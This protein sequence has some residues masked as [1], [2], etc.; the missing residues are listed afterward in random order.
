VRPSKFFVFGM[1]F[2]AALAVAAWPLYESVLRKGMPW[3]PNAITATY[4]STQLRQTG[5]GDATV[6]LAYELENNTNADYW[7]S[8]SPRYVIMNRL[9]S[10]GSLNSQDQPRLSYSTFL[11]AHQR[12][13]ITLQIQRPFIWPA[14]DDPDVANRLTEF[15]AQRLS[16][17]QA[18]VLFDQPDHFEVDFPSGWQK[19]ELASETGK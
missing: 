14:D 19:L 10:D 2:A 16:G 3:D 15:V 1:V 6:F 7:L 18:F 9:E 4:Q 8:D 11:P 12:A 13:Q 5:Q 17:V